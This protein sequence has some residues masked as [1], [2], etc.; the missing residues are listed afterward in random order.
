LT[1]RMMMFSAP[2]LAI[3]SWALRLIPSPMASN[4]MTLET[5]MKMPS[6]VRAE[7]SG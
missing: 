4:Q 2:R 7:R 6:T 3:C 1:E 5:P